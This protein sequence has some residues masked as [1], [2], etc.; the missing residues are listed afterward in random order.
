[1]NKVMLLGRL[2]KD[3]E[4][5]TINEDK[6]VATFNLAVNRRFRKEGEPDADFINCVAWNKT[7]ELIEKYI[8]KGRQIAVS[9]RLNTR[10]YEDKE[11]SK[12]YVT[13][14]IVDEIDF[15]DSKKEEKSEEQQEFFTGETDDLP[16]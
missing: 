8:T 12:R 7:A 15:A 10:S 2:T 11:G 14:V 3:A 16:F 13:E 1:M 5:K 4:I 6:K 9:G